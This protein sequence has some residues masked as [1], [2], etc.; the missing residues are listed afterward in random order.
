MLMRDAEGRMKEANKVKPTTKQANTTHP[1]QSLFQGK[2]EL[3]IHVLGV[4][5]CFALFVCLT[6]LL[7]SFFLLISHLKTC[8]YMYYRHEICYVHVYTLQYDS[9]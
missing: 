8:T 6:C 2:N 7:L 1:R 9:I 3:P 5:C 4:L